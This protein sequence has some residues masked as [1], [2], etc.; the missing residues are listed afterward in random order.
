[1]ITALAFCPHPPLLVPE[2][3]RG[4]AG[5]L[6]EV[7][8]ACDDAVAAA[9]DT[10]PDLVVVLGGGPQP[11]RWSADAVGTL[12]GFGVPLDVPLT[13]G[14][15]GAGSDR[16][17][18][19]LTVGAWLL[20]RSTWQGERTAV[21]VA[22]DPLGGPGERRQVAEQL[23]G[24]AQ[25]IALLVMADGSNTRSEKAPGSFHPDAAEFDGQVAAVLR[26]GDPAPGRKVTYD[27]AR[28]VGAQGWS[29]WRTAFHAAAGRTWDAELRYDA[30]PYGVGYLVA[31]WT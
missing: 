23:T 16:L 7:R 3:A 6:D 15:Q 26:S 14:A 22:A 17:P 5:E 31:S 20:A 11:R 4:A 19:S 24:T 10:G 29:A 21:E 30:A 8:R 28:A 1:M 25:R 9:L 13:P 12:R 18:L 2:V 27:D